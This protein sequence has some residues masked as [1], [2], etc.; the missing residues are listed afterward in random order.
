ML[1]IRWHVE[2]D[3]VTL[4]SHTS[5]SPQWH[6]VFSFS[7]EDLFS[8]KVTFCQLYSLHCFLVVL[9]SKIYTSIF[10]SYINPHLMYVATYKRPFDLCYI[11]I[12]QPKHLF[13]YKSRLIEFMHLYQY[14]LIKFRFFSLIHIYIYIPWPEIQD[15][16]PQ[17]I[18][19]VFLMKLFIPNK[20]KF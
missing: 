13:L 4:I 5:V 6:K 2:A 12:L 18:S 17:Y 20:R 9:K 19:A 11:I 8:W 7:Q 15:M 14:F 3:C 1:Y 10:A 16:R